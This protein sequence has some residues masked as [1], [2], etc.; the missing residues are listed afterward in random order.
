MITIAVQCHNFQRRFW[1]MLSSLAVQTA[2]ASIV[3]DVAHVPGN[4]A[5]T[6]EEVCAIF[7]ELVRRSEFEFDAKFRA[8]G[9]VRNVQMSECQTEWIMFADCDMVYHPTYF[10][11]L[12]A[13]LAAHHPEARHMIGSGRTSNPIGE[14]D[15]LVDGSAPIWPR[16]IIEP[17]QQASRLA[18]VAMENVGAGYCQI[19][20][21]KHG[22]HGGYYVRPEECRDWPWERRGSNFV[23]DVRFRKRM[24]EAAGMWKALPQW[25]SDN[26]IHLNHARDLDHGRHLTEQR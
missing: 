26:A 3:V 21:M 18:R 12:L 8:R 25:F 14:A 23:S 17:F 9:L 13:H 16:P 4:G 1:W 19:V 7:P 15:A 20:S 2:A 24:V 11:N 5:P 6:T 10:E 22:A